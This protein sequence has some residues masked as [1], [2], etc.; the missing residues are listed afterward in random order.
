MC[1]LGTGF[2]HRSRRFVPEHHGR[3]DDEM[4]D[5]AMS[6]IMDIRAADA[7]R[8]GADKHILRPEFTGSCSTGN[9]KIPE[10]ELAFFFQHQC[11]HL[12]LRS[13]RKALQRIQTA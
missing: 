5:L 13:L 7:D 10:R 6:I 1:Y 9:I 2:D 4:T 3:I 12:I 11:L 8:M